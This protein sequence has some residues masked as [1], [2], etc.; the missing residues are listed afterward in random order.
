[1][2]NNPGGKGS[3]PRPLSVPT[4]EFDRRWAAIF[5]PKKTPPPPPPKNDQ[6]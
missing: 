5:A 3:V 4:E 1:M 6:N 2:S